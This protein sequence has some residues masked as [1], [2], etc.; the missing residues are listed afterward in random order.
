MKDFMG[1]E[2]KVGDNVV[3]VENVNKFS[4]LSK[5]TVKKFYS[6]HFGEDE[7]TVNSKSHVT[8]SRIMKLEEEQED[9]MERD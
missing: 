3:F 6:G 2:L 7:C 8:S 1:K 4:N 5:G 9:D